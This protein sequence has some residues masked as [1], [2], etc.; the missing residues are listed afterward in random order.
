MKTP[1]Q[2]AR[3]IF[4]ARAD[5]YT[6]SA[7]HT[8]PWVLGRVVELSAPELDW[9][10]LDL[11][12]GTGHTVFAIAPHVAHVTGLDLTP[13]MLA[14]AVKLQAAKSIANASWLI[15]DVHRLPCDDAAF[16]LVI[17]RRAAHHFSDIRQSLREMRRVLR[18]GGRLVIDDRSVP[19]DDFVDA[20]MNQLDHYHDESHVR[21]Y[22]PAEWR[23]ML[24]ARAMWSR[25]W[26]HTP[27]T[28]RCRRSPSGYRRTTCAVS[29]RRWTG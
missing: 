15:A 16:Q 3:Q 29:T 21:Q 13:E 14:E 28:G 8:D 2:T 7:A 20:C 27:D 9:A 23:Q 22:R 26:S 17:C 1:E 6:T 5:K 10:V 12:T 4:G 19:E 25:P 11:G 24:E 18:P